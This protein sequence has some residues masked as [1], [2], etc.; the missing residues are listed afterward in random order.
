MAS[1]AKVKFNE[2]Y[3]D[4]AIEGWNS[5][6]DTACDG[7]DTCQAAAL[8][9]CELADSYQDFARAK[10]QQ[11]LD[12]GDVDNLDG[13]IAGMN[14]PN[15]DTMGSYACYSSSAFEGMIECIKVRNCK[16]PSENT[17]YLTC[18]GDLFGIEIKA[19]GE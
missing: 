3:Q 4:V 5:C 11:E 16:S 18:M 19:A 7:Y 14:D 1:C 12:C 8:K 10:C 2:L 17:A 9:S 15:K 6:L 13:C